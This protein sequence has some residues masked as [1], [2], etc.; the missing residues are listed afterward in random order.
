MNEQEAPEVKNTW[1]TIYCKKNNTPSIPVYWPSNLFFPFLQTLQW[2]KMNEDE[3]PGAKKTLKTIY[4]EKNYSSLISVYWPSNL[5]SHFLQDSQCREMNEEEAPEVK[6]HLKDR[7]K[8]WC[9]LMTAAR[10][11]PRDLSPDSRHLSLVAEYSLLAPFCEWFC[12]AFQ[13]TTRVMER[14]VTGGLCDAGKKGE[15]VLLLR[16]TAWW[17]HAPSDVIPGP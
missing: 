10:W 5:L 2:R 17:R 11:R 15:N 12:V 7:K 6:K 3:A 14:E 4:C 8:K 13:C 16:W 9:R 1:K